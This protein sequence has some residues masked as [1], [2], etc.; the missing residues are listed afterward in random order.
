MGQNVDHE[1]N[2]MLRLEK[3]RR[4]DLWREADQGFGGETRFSEPS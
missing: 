4:P 1:E 3:E 2:G